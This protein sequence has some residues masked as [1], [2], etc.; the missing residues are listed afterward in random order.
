MA[1]ELPR[2][3]RYFV[4]VKPL[5]GGVLPTTNEPYTIDVVLAST[6]DMLDGRVNNS[7]GL[8]VDQSIAYVSN[9]I[10]QNNNLLGAQPPKTLVYVDFDGSVS[11]QVEPGQIVSAFDLGVV[12]SSLD[13]AENLLINGGGGVT[14]ILDNVLA[15]YRDVP[16]SFDGTRFNVQLIGSDLSLYRQAE[17]GLFFTT[18]DPALSGL[19]RDRDFTSILVGASSAEFGLFGLASQI[20]LGNQSKGDEAILFLQNF[21]LFA[22]QLTGSQTNRL[23]QM[24][25]AIGN[26]LAHELAHTMGLNHTESFIYADDPDNNPQSPNDST[27]GRINLIAAG[28]AVDFLRITEELIAMGTSDLVSGEFGLGQN[29]TNDM[30]SLW[31]S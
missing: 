20:D 19:Q 21:S 23:N 3:G 6:D 5:S 11:T 1:F 12:S 27:N 7:A 13:G 22:T 24:S 26:V 4:G 17:S 16:A 28:P 10:G 29:D 2:T 30:L 15:I 18:I 25:R 9:F 14:S 31:L 8:P